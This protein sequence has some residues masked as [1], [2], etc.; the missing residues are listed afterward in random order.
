M[1]APLK[2]PSCSRKVSSQLLKTPCSPRPLNDGTTAERR[3]QI[4]C[5]LQQS[6]ELCL[7]KQQAQGL[8]RAATTTNSR[9]APLST[10]YGGR[11]SG[12]KDRSESEID[13]RDVTG[14]D[15]LRRREM[16]QETTT[17]PHFSTGSVY[18]FLP[19]G[20]LAPISKCLQRFRGS[21]ILYLHSLHSIR[22]VT[23]F[24]VFAFFLNTAARTVAERKEHPT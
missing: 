15:S 19:P 13:R 17:T 18:F 22:S 10:T 1:S 3:A 21:C 14:S 16:P 20:L 24:V 11:R 5:A 7:P 4:K 12:A 2:R 9:L 23:F 6:D 8:V